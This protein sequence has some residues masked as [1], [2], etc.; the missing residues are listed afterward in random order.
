MSSFSYQF[1]RKYPSRRTVLERLE[2][3][4]GHE[5]EWSDFTGDG[6][7]AISDAFE[8]I[9]ANSRRFYFQAIKSVLNENLDLIEGKTSI[10][11]EKREPSQAVYLNDSEIARIE[12]ISLPNEELE[13]ARDLFLLCCYEGCRHS[14]GVN[15]TRANIDGRYL[16]YVPQKT[17]N[18]VVSVPLHRNAEKHIVERMEMRD[19]RYND[20]IRTICMRC[21]IND[22]MT[23]FRKGKNETAPKWSFV[24]SHTARRSFATNLYRKGANIND[25]SMMMGH[26][27][28]TV[29]LRYIVG[30]KELDETTLNLFN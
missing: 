18:L 26:T 1:L 25:I 29:T 14:D 12:T 17:K 16:R 19:A 7:R 8:D 9:S 23:V 27:N 30:A 2:T 28:M 5:P 4:F 15:I 3:T 22:Q 6:L 24:S 11:N 10:L 13:Y 21:G 20:L